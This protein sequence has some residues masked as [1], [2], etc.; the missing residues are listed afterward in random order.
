MVAA[1]DQQ[2]SW[3]LR[4]FVAATTNPPRVAKGRDAAAGDVVG[5]IWRQPSPLAPLPPQRS[6]CRRRR[7]RRGDQVRV[8]VCQG[9][10]SRSG[11]ATGGEVSISSSALE[12]W[13]GRQAGQAVVVGWPAAMAPSVERGRTAVGS[14]LGGAAPGTTAMVDDEGDGARRC[15]G[16]RWNAGARGGGAGPAQQ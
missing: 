2:W 6:L 5:Q 11:L 4:L 13:P 12:G 3:A 7:R 14:G 10:G 9:S 15:G 1:V 8:R 16:R